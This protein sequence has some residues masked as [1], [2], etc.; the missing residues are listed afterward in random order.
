MRD[1]LLVKSLL[2][3]PFTFDIK[4]SFVLT[5][6]QDVRKCLLYNNLGAFIISKLPFL[7]LERQ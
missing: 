3:N 7:L 6:K 1:F 5:W 4:D 2:I